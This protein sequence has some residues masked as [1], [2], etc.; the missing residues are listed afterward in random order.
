MKGENRKGKKTELIDFTRQMATLLNS[1]IKLTEALTVLTLQCS[2]MRFKNAVVDIR[3][4]VVTGESLTDAFKDYSDYFD[5]IYISMVRV[6]EV[7]G[8]LASSFAS[9]S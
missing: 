3:D 7:T 5:I 2:D 1:G 8:S 6:G 4:R 9:K